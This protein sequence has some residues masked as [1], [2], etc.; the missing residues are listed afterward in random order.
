MSSAQAQAIRDARNARVRAS[1]GLADIP[2]S[3]WTYEQ[4]I[5]YN[6]ALSAAV[7]ADASNPM[8]AV[9][10]QEIATARNVAAKEYTPL[11]SYGLGDAAGDF[12]AE[13]INQTERLNP[14]SERNWGGTRLVI[15]GAI[16]LAA[17]VYFG[18]LAS[19]SRA[20]LTADK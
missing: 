16:L 14:L 15:I 7:L 1:L 18:G 11:E 3:S 12:T 9:S 17:V 10:A 4:R 6:K 5:A 19:K 20:V 8:G 2:P 13:F